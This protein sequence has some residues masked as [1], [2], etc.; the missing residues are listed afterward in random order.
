VKDEDSLTERGELLEIAC[1]RIADLDQPAYVKN[2]DLRYVAVNR[3]YARFFQR[4]VSDFIGQRSGDLFD[5]SEECDRED[6]ERRALVFGGE[7]LA[8]CIDPANGNAVRV[9]VERFLPT[10]DRPYVRDVP[11]CRAW[12]ARQFSPGGE[13]G[14]RRGRRRS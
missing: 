8:I 10:E 13:S 11:G 7:E 6:K 4:D 14:F 3:A 12:Q 2:S 9:E 1:R 5:S